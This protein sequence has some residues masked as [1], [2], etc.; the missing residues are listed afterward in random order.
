MKL[1]RRYAFENGYG[2]MIV[3]RDIGSGLNEKGRG[4]RKLLKMI[5]DNV[6]SKVIVAYPDRLIRF[7]F[8]TLE[9]FFEI[10]GT[11][12]IIIKLGA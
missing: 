2:D 11:E 1:V 8:K 12:V 4:F 7:G 3:L 10:Y 6:V 9:Y 5:T